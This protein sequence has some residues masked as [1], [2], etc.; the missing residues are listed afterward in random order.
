MILE[1]ETSRGDILEVDFD[2]RKA[3]KYIESR[4]EAF[5]LR[6]ETSVKGKIMFY[7]EL[8]HNKLSSTSQSY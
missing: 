2:A 6:L 1:M 4:A 8:H 7:R 3:S 5:C